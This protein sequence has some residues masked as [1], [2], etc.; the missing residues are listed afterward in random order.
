M[1][2]AFVISTFFTY[3]VIPITCFQILYGMVVLHMHHRKNNSDFQS[4]KYWN[5]CFSQVSV[6]MDG[7]VM[8]KGYVQGDEYV[9]C[10]GGGC[11]RSHGIPPLEMGLGIPPPWGYWHL[12]VA[13]K[14][15]AVG[16]QM[17]RILLECFFVLQI[18]ASDKLQQQ[19]CILNL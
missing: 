18:A 7:W 8:F 10:P 14:T 6:H 4:N 5:F 13:T 2:S 15:H 16:K 3:Y 19:K 9:Q 12:V 11:P 1:Y 17:V